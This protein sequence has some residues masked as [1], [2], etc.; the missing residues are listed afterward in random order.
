MVLGYLYCC[1]DPCHPANP[2]IIP[3][4]TPPRTSTIATM[5]LP[6]I[7]A[8]NDSN[9]PLLS[10]PVELMTKIFGVL[11]SFFDVIALAATCRRLRHIWTTNVTSIYSQVSRSIPCERY[12]RRFLTDQGGPATSFPT[13]SARDAMCIV[14][15]SC[16]VEKAIHQ[17]EWD[18]VCRINSMF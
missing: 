16:V 14:R 6:S 12:A 13:L 2:I 8:V 3:G 10:M 17:F 1:N 18:V 15:N 11:P 4:I 9:G 7:Q 5:Q